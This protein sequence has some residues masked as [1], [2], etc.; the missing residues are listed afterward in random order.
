MLAIGL[1]KG[2]PGLDAHN[3]ANE[4]VGLLAPSVPC[5]DYRF[6][7]MDIGG[8]VRWD[9]Y[10]RI[11]NAERTS[12]DYIGGL[13]HLNG[14]GRV[15]VYLDANALDNQ[16]DGGLRTIGFTMCGPWTPGQALPTATDAST[17]PTG[18]RAFLTDLG[19]VLPNLKTATAQGPVLAVAQI[20]VMAQ[21]LQA[22]DTPDALTDPLLE[23]TGKPTP[24]LVFPMCSPY[25][26]LRDP[27][28]AMAA[29]PPPDAMVRGTVQAVESRTNDMAKIVKD[30]RPESPASDALGQFVRLQ[31][32]TVDDM[33]I[34]VACR[35]TDIQGE[36]RVGAAVHVLG[37]ATVN[38]VFDKEMDTAWQ[39]DTTG[40]QPTQLYAGDKS[41]L[42]PP[43]ALQHGAKSHGKAQTNTPPPP[44]RNLGPLLCIF[45][46]L[47]AM[48]PIFL[49]TPLSLIYSLRWLFRSSDQVSAVGRILAAIGVA[50]STLGVFAGW[51]LFKVLG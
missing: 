45:Y 9:T 21:T 14:P 4:A 18:L 23:V 27:I 5:D 17:A 2:Q 46:S 50:I 1:P 8:G 3:A 15:L 22:A 38:L 35:P 31:V 20:S 29:P 41:Q 30:Q 36:A 7:R 39:G 12:I 16:P 24:G 6:A 51:S 43:L 37:S 48:L 10:F 47:L 32:K 34:E 25:V 11:K 49:L 42:Q 44:P 33:L 19:F 13:P 28:R 26:S 40:W